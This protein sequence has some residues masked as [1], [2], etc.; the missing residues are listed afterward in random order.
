MGLPMPPPPIIGDG[1]A[2]CDNVLWLPGATPKNP[3]ALVAGLVKCPMAPHDPPDGP[4]IMTQDPGVPCWW[5]YKDAEFQMHCGVSAVVSF[6]DIY[7]FPAAGWW[8]FLGRAGPCASVFTNALVGCL[9][10]HG[11]KLGT[12]TMLW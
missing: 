11:T 9:P 6:F 7:D 12:V 5:W 10:T 3:T 1:C 4:Y 2:M 8:W